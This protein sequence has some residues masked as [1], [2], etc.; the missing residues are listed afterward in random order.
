MTS[1]SAY[2]RLADSKIGCEPWPLCQ[3]ENIQIDKNPG[4]TITAADD[5][6]GLR[7]MHRLMA[8]SFGILAILLV[9][10]SIWYRRDI[11]TSPLLAITCFILTVILAVVGM[12][13]PDLLHPVITFTNLTAGMMTIAVLWLLVLRLQSPGIAQ[14]NLH[15]LA[16]IFLVI[17][18][19]GSG[20]WVSANYA[21]SACHGLMN[22]GPVSLEEYSSAFNPGRELQLIGTSIVPG[23]AAS[24]IGL[25]HRLMVLLLMTS[26]AVIA[27]R[28]Y[29]APRSMSGETSFVILFLMMI[30]V[31][32]SVIEGG[33]PSLLSAWLHNFW[34]TL[35][36]LAMVF[37][38]F[39]S[40]EL[41]EIEQTT[42]NSH[43]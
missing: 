1:L 12:A 31:V 40:G 22:C 26:L 11:R 20:A 29:R 39:L 24:I 28:H 13:T 15:G 21:T 35:L 41:H 6:K 23:E 42:R 16:N 27:Y 19:I 32:T 30:I 38:Y 2:I 36:L 4:I 8:S 7:I 9:L 25:T 34:S 37:H 18:V 10:L 14:P 43:Q 17:A 5:N 33:K 3:M